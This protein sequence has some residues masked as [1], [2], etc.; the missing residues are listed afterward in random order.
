MYYHDI[1]LLFCRH[2]AHYKLSIYALLFNISIMLIKNDAVKKMRY[3]N[4]ENIWYYFLN[5]ITRERNLRSKEN[6]IR[7]YT[8]H[9]ILRKRN[10]SYSQV[11]SIFTF[12]V[13][14]IF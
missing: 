10:K 5:V 6:R 3:F 8:V 4:I 2:I 9:T 13:L 1:M 7:G 12:F 14:K 11:L